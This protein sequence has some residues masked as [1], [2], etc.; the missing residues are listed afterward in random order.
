MTAKV[1]SKYGADRKDPFAQTFEYDDETSSGSDALGLELGYGLSVWEG[2]LTPYI[3]TDLNGGSFSA[4]RLGFT[5]IRGP[6]SLSLE[7]GLTPGSGSTQ[8]E[9]E[10]TLTGEIRF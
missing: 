4:A 5:F 1:T 7:H 10:L 8:A 3:E 6:A 2:L 9:H